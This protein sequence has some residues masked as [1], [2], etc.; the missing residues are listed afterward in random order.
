MAK[1]ES[2]NTGNRQGNN[3]YS[4]HHVVNPLS[5]NDK[6]NSSS[7]VRSST[8][9][10]KTCYIVGNSQFGDNWC[11]KLLQKKKKRIMYEA[12]AS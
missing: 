3:I 7:E 4:N 12:Q 11:S 1:L 9:K 5:N 8:A 2:G 6:V 10:K